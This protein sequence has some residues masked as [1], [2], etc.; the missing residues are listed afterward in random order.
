LPENIYWKAIA[1]FLIEKCDRVFL[2]REE[3]IAKM[4]KFSHV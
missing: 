2:N 4:L 3:A 1:F